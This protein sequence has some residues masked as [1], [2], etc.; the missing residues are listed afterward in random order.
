M[1]EPVISIASDFSRAPAGRYISDG[2][3]SG[4]RFRDSLLVPALKQHDVIAVDLDGTR[5]LGSSF[6]EEVFGGLIRLGFSAA[7]LARRVRLKSEDSSLVA[8]VR[9]Y[10][11]I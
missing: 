4:E 10:W 1:V 6:L 3:N 9:G 5:G 11:G 2:P 7:D 8:E